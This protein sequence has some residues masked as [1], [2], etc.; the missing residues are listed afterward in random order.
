MTQY[1]T[2]QM[3]AWREAN[4]NKHLCKCG[5]GQYVQPTRWRWYNG[6]NLDYIAGHHPASVHWAEDNCNWKGG[7]YK[8]S[9]GYWLIF[10]PDH[11]EADSKGY[12]REH[13]LVME[14]T[15]GRYLKDHEHVHHINGV[16]DDNRP[17]NLR[18]MGASEHH[19]LHARYRENHPNWVDVS[20]DEILALREEGLPINEI[21]RRLGVGRMTVYRRLYPE[22][23][24]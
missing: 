7:R 5:C 13:R 17:E 6:K 23:G 24:Y 16:K 10:H 9:G 8:N 1:F 15:L 19:L 11:P 3:I 18:L 21:A 4:T 22:R 14:K 12:V 2:R 20:L